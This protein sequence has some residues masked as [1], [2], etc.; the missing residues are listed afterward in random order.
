MSLQ[1]LTW[2]LANH[3]SL[4]NL[5]ISFRKWQKPE[6]LYGSKNYHKHLLS[7]L[8]FSKAETAIKYPTLVKFIRN[9]L[10]LYLLF[11]DLSLGGIYEPR[12]NVCNLLGLQLHTGVPANAWDAVHAPQIPLI[13]RLPSQPNTFTN[14]YI[15]MSEAPMLVQ[16]IQ[17]IKGKLIFI[18]SK[19]LSPP[20]FWNISPNL[21]KVS[22]IHNSRLTDLWRQG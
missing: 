14:S 1:P 6:Y 7:S 18:T 9:A 4:L 15:I 13:M 5:L 16:L 19:V 22:Y 3:L 12:E 2:I 8:K 20:S 11:Q 10:L 17:G 21:N